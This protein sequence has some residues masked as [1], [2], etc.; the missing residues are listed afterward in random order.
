M[1]YTILNLRLVIATSVHAVE[2]QYI[3]VDRFHV[4]ELSAN[5][6]QEDEFCMKLRKIGGKWWE[7]YYDY[8]QATGYKVRPMYREEREI[9]FLGWPEDG[10]V[11]L[12]RFSNPAHLR[13][14]GWYI[15]LINNALTMEERRKAIE[16]SGG[17]FFKRPEDSE[18]IRP[19]L[20]GLGN[21]GSRRDDERGWSD[22]GTT[23]DWEP[24]WD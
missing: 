10:G 6:T 1:Y 17:T 22:L 21:H 4:T 20:E 3:G 13:N 15:G 2:L 19:L 23:G 24:I 16:M 7:D 11:W 18:Y 14:R 8:D 12:L 9:L 5:A